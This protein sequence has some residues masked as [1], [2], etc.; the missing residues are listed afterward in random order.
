MIEAAAKNKLATQMGTQIHAGSN[1]RRVVELVQGGAIG[2]VSEVHVWHPVA[3]GG[4]TGVPTDTPPVPDG[5][6]WDLWLGPA[7]VRPYHPAYCPVVWRGWWDFG[8]GG[9]GD[10]GCHYMDLPFGR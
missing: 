8:S 5:L 1:Y 4:T 2:P 9:L 10:F 7:A 3:Y 6:D